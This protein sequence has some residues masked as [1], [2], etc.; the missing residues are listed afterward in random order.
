MAKTPATAS[1]AEDLVSVRLL[2]GYVPS[3]AKFTTPPDEPNTRI[4]EKSQP[5]DVIQIP[6]EEAQA[7]VDA[8]KA[9]AVF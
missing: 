4:Y 5:G 3:N 1:E 9:K 8:D 6:R 7:L 2:Y